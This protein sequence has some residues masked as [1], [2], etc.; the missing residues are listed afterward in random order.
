MNNNF[1]NQQTEIIDIEDSARTSQHPLPG[2]HYKIKVD[3]DLI[4]FTKERVTGLE[5][6]EAACRTPAECFR[7]YLKRKDCELIKIGFDEVVDL[8]KGDIEHFVTK[9]PDIFYYD[10][11]EE[12]RTTD[13]KEMTPDQI[14]ISAG[15]DP[16]THYLVQL[17]PDGS[18]ENYKGKGQEP[19]K[20]KC[21]CMKFISILDGPCPVS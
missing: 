10:L 12:S 18:K 1:S 13:H 11:D 3:D 19:I 9:P 6:L 15:I 17:F 16:R 8:I 2:R 14:L 4:I 21:P 7:L 20:M 5:I